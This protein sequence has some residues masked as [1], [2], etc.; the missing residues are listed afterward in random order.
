MAQPRNPKKP[1]FNQGAMQ[2]Y[3]KKADGQSLKETGGRLHDPIPEAK[4]SLEE[5]AEASLSAHAP[6]LKKEVLAPERMLQPIQ[7]RGKLREMT[8]N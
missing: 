5:A 3:L 1:V 8:F 4:V 7:G 2:R 6:F